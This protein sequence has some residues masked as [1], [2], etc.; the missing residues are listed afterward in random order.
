MM[1][2]IIQNTYNDWARDEPKQEMI[3][4][5]DDQSKGCTKT[6]MNQGR[7]VQARDEPGMQAGEALKQRSTKAKKH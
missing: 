2:T 7:D 5:R 4:D 6:E 3:E 1:K